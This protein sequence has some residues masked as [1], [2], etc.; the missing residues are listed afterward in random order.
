M[1]GIA[2]LTTLLNTVLLLHRLV[3]LPRVFP[4]QPHVLRHRG[5]GGHGGRGGRG[6]LVEGDLAVLQELVILQLHVRVVPVLGPAPAPAPADG[7]RGEGEAGLVVAYRV[8]VLGGEADGDHGRARVLLLPAH[9][10]G[11]RDTEPSGHSHRAP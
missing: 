8:S 9:P 10:G 2:V 11:H 6:G 5:R 7:G 3:L 4:L 1:P